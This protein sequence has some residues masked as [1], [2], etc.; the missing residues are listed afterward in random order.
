MGETLVRRLRIKHEDP[1]ESMDEED[2]DSERGQRHM[3]EFRPSVVS[4][5]VTTTIIL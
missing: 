4:V 5:S 1:S 2:N 3:Q